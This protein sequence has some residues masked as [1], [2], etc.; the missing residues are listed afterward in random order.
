MESGLFVSKNM[1]LIKRGERTVP[2]LTAEKGF[3]IGCG[4]VRTSK[5][6][7][8]YQTN[9]KT[10][11]LE[12]LFAGYGITLQG[13]IDLLWDKKIPLKRFLSTK[14]CPNDYPINSG[15]W[16]ALVYKQASQI[17]RSCIKKKRTSKP[18][19]ENISIELSCLVFD[20]IK[21]NKE[22]D[23]F[24]KITLPYYINGRRK[25]INI[26]IRQHK[27]SLR[28]IKWNRKNTIKLIKQNGK[29]YLLF[30]YEKEQPVIK[31]TGISIGIDQGYKKLLAISD[32]KIIGNG[33]DKI[34]E[35][36]ARKQQGSKNFLQTLTRRNDLI[37]ELINKNLK[38]PAV[39][40]IVIENLKNVKRNTKGK[41]RKKFNNKLQRWCYPKVVA[42][43]ERLCEEDGVY[44]SKVDPSY[45]SQTCSKCGEIHKESRKNEVYECVSCGMK[46]DADINAAIN[47]LH[48]GGYQPSATGKET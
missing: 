31:Q 48:R 42:K 25:T 16:K 35:T 5:H 9:L 3:F 41:F 37:N 46:M 23:E 20:I 21:G 33:F 47:I 17:I 26:P 13:Y 8:K 24:V 34:Y 19:I 28:F 43:I 14:D 4:M 44:L 10:A 32:G 22:F 11:W 27:Q 36:I 38:T 6:I 45:T 39:N 7:L 18:E 15:Q 30:F 2:L 12:K 1:P 29:Y 40:R